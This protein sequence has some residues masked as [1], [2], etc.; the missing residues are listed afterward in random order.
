LIELCA[1]CFE[2]APGD[3]RRD[4]YRRAVEAHLAGL[5]GAEARAV[6][7]RGVERRFDVPQG[8][9]PGA[10]GVDRSGARW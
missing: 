10:A 6:S 5:A 8:L 7:L 1:A 4:L 2:V 3:D 9:L